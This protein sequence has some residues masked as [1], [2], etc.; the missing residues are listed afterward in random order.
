MPSPSI[1]GLL[2]CL[3]T[4]LLYAYVSATASNCKTCSTAWRHDCVFIPRH[5]LFVL[6]VAEFIK[7]AGMQR[8]MVVSLYL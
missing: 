5:C 8:L 7:L 4:V 2:E 1:G 3:L 6:L